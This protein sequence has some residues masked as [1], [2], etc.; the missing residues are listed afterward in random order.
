MKGLHSLLGATRDVL[1]HGVPA[2]R[3]LPVIN[4]APKGPRARAELTT[5]FAAL[6]GDADGAVGVPGPLYLGERRQLE[7]ALPRRG[8]VARELVG[9]VAGSVRSLLDRRPGQPPT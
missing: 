1:A 3:V 9:A 7:D 6:L 8:P 4:R 5:A 2:A